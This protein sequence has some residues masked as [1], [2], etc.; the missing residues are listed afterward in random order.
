MRDHIKIVGILNIVMGSITALVGV[1]IL[2]MMGTIAG[3]VAASISSLDGTNYQNGA[4]AAPIVA[5]I[6]VALAI[7]FLALGLPSILGGWG[8]MHYRPWSRILMIVVSVFHLFHIPLGTALGVY[9]LWVLLSDESRRLLE[10]GGAFTAPAVAGGY[11]RTGYPAPPSY[12]PPPSA[13]PS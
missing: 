12:G 1:V 4:I 10:S 6:G 7:F 3:F 5:T 13:P 9:G 11:G 2:L 8:L